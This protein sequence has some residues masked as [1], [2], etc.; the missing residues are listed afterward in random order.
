MLKP[1]A[2]R[3]TVCVPIRMYSRQLL[4]AGA[5]SDNAFLLQYRFNSTTIAA[6]TALRHSE[7]VAHSLRMLL[8]CHFIRSELFVLRHSERVIRD[9]HDPDCMRSSKVR[10]E[11]ENV[12]KCYKEVHKQKMK[13]DTQVSIMKFFVIIQS[14]SAFISSSEPSTSIGQT[15]TPEE[16]CH[17]QYVLYPTPIMTTL[18]K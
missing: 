6:T 13:A 18:I 15:A 14:E 11:M 9:E 1:L 16:A 8:P 2:E 3:P 7:R 4:Q 5:C 17:K 10:R 12:L